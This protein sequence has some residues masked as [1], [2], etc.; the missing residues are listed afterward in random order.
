MIDN[1]VDLRKAQKHIA[2][3]AR[4]IHAL[5]MD[6]VKT[7]PRVLIPRGPN[8]RRT[9]DKDRNFPKRY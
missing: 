7:F 9:T 6:V 1:D 4:G 8:K 5:R 3:V 2:R